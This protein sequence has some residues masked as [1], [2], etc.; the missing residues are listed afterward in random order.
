VNQRETISFTQMQWAGEIDEASAQLETL[1]TQL[2]RG[3]LNQPQYNQ[4]VVRPAVD[5][6]QTPDSVVVVVE[7]P[8]MTGRR[9]GLEIDGGRL[10]IW[11]EKGGRA[12]TEPA[13]FSQV[14]IAAGVF[15]RSVELPAEVDPERAAYRYEDGYLEVRLPRTQRPLGRIVRL[16]LRQT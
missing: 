15:R 13:A 4:P 3:R 1:W 6:Y 11:G 10:T 9:V 2:R 5:V 14:E 16:T 12:C 8:G 7:I